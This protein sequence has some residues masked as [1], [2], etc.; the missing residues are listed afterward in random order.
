MSNVQIKIDKSIRLED[1]D[2]CYEELYNYI[3][4]NI[5]VDLL[6]PRE[7]NNYYL[8]LVPTLYQFAITW[9]RY[10][11]SG[12]LMLDIEDPVET[13]FEKIYE[14]ELLFPLISL[15]WNK[16][17]VFNRS[18]TINLRSYL[19]PKNIDLFSK[20]RA[21]KPLKGR[22]LLLTNFDHLPQDRGLLPCFE[23][24]HEFIKNESIL[25]DSL[26]PGISEVLNYS[27]EVELQ[28]STVAK[29]LIGIVYELMKN[30]YEWAKDDSN[31]VQLDP[32]M[33]GVLIKF[34]KKKRNT[35]LEDFQN[36]KGLTEYFSSLVLKENSINELY[37][38]E[39]SVFDSGIGFVEKYKSLNNAKSYTDIEIVKKCMIKH[40]TSAKGLNKDDKGI[41]LDRILSI[42]NEKGF[43]RIKTG[44]VCVYRNLISHKYQ[45]VSS[46]D[47]TGMELFDWNKNSNTDYT[48]N[49]NAEGSVITIIYPL[50]ITLQ[51]E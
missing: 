2:S 9:I 28:Y 47:I 8:G 3:K 32:N 22:K 50:S 20:M 38:L 43:L 17:E 21:V 34:Y 35:F 10:D 18:G 51:N 24:N 19:R 29:H 11:R 23:I 15:A 6:I 45:S 13:D 37:F 49:K 26:T 41:G 7:L 44:T 48:T 5:V 36:Q 33:R 16:N 40:N 25:N 4:K 1:I 46:D 14:N 39:L 12:K 31:Q 27:K 30:T 42:L